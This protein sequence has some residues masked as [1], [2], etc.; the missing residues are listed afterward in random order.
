[1]TATIIIDGGGSG[2]RARLH[3]TDGAVTV[4]LDEPL[5]L[6]TVTARDVL[7]RLGRLLDLL[8]VSEP[9]TAVTVG[10][11]GGASTARSEPVAAML[12]GRHPG[13]KVVVARDV[14]LVL[15]H[16]DRPGA[17]LVVGTGAVVLAPTSNGAEVMIDG[18]G[19]SI[20]DRGGG[21]WI[22]L[23]A[24]RAT[25]RS[26]DLD[27]TEPRLLRALR[28]ELGLATD[29][30][31]AAAIADAGGPGARNVAALAP[32]V[33][34]LAQDGEPDASAIL[35]RAVAEIAASVRAGLRRAGCPPGARVVAAGGLVGA[36]AYAAR[37]ERAVVDGD[38]VAHLRAVD[39]L[40]TPLARRAI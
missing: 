35:D 14:D 25:L 17:A 4:A 6:T 26:R 3:G 37:L 1:V 19:F 24:L 38:T 18:H 13:A 32:V 39:P 10:L 16:L 11:A 33:L 40:E 2:A 21:A 8:S 7:R 15:A 20:G 34:A 28:G 12:R 36:P 22:G 27:G 23:E 5:S 30:G 9:V 31:I 29:R